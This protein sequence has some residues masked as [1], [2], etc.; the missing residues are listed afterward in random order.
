MAE[1]YIRLYALPNNVYL[2]GAPVLIAAGALLLDSQTGRVLAQLKLQNISEK[3]VRS[4]TVAVYPLDVAQRPMGEA[5]KY[6]YLD[7]AAA[8]DQMFGQQTP[9]WMPD[10]SARAFTARVTEVV[11][12]GNEIWTAPEGEWTALPPEHLLTETFPDPELLKQ[13]QMHY[14]ENTTHYPERFRDLWRCACGAINHAA[15]TGCH[16]CTR[17]AEALLSCDVAALAEEKNARVAKEK[18]ER[19]AAEAAER[20][21]RAE[22]EAARKAK[23]AALTKQAIKIAKIAVPALIVVIAAVLIVTKIVIPTTRYNKAAELLEAGKYDEAIAAFEAMDGYKDSD[24]QIAEAKR[25]K[26]DEQKRREA[27]QKQKELD[28]AI[29]EAKKLEKA[30]KTAE[31]AMAYGALIDED[32]SCRERSFA[33]WD[34]IAQRKTIDAG[35]EHSVGLFTDGTVVAKGNNGANR[36]GVSAWKNIIAIDGGHAHTVGLHKDGTVVAVGNNEDGEC[37]VADW[38]D[39]VAIAAGSCHTLAVRADGSVCAAGRSGALG[40]A[41]EWTNI[42][43]VAAGSWFSVGLRANGTVVAD[44]SEEYGDCDVATWRDIVAVSAQG[45]HTVGLHADGTVI[46]TGWARDGQCDVSEWTDIVAIATGW[47]HTVGLRADGTVV[48]TGLNKDGQCD[49]SGWTDI[50]AIAAGDYYTLG[51]RADGT[52]VAVGMNRDERCDLSDW[53]DIKLPSSKQ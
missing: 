39:I 34:K 51:L 26:A 17:E 16:A 14:G 48:A 25:Q 11:F 47:A 21:R 49:V 23:I 2:D 22:A 8:R 41:A 31:A 9:I 53:T 50:V 36:C 33:L 29:E 45:M 37:D 18:A 52:I 3:A 46:A 5:V 42:V 28:E 4:V 1:R 44:G 35:A 24:D 19:E 40:N 6:Q 30:G 32:P 20:K 13:Y 15:E 43:S 27:E 38:T 12:A 10:A 7:L